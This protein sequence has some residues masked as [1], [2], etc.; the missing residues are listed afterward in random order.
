MHIYP[1][2]RRGSRAAP[3]SVD[4][5]QHSTHYNELGCRTRAGETCPFGAYGEK[6]V[7]ELGAPGLD[8][9]LWLWMLMA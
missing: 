8:Y 4:G 3:R 7:F 5:M 1:A 2:P 6:L 9:Y